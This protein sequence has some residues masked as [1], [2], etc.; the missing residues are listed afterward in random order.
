MTRRSL[1]ASPSAGHGRRNAALLAAAGAGAALAAFN[2]VRARRAER[3]HPPTGRLFAIGGVRVHVHMAGEGPPLVLLNGNGSMVHDWLVSG[4]FDRLRRS[5][6]VIAVDRPGYGYTERPRDRLWTPY[7]QAELVRRTLAHLGV[8]KPIVLGHSWGTIVA[9]ALAL[10]H[11]DAVRGL[12]LL[13]GYYFPTA[14]VDVWAFSPPAIPVFG[15]IM[16]YTVSP[17]LLRLLA[18]RIIRKLFEPMPVPPRFAMRFPLDLALRPSQLKASAEDSAL[19]VPA[20][21]GLQK[22]YGELRLPIEIL[23]GTE[24]RVVTP[25]RQ[26]GRLH[27]TIRGSELTRLPGLGHMV[28]YAA[29]DEIVRAVGAVATAADERSEAEALSRAVHPRAALEARPM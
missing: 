19:M 2:Y 11:P 10:E 18:P 6:R 28:H 1:P 12:V 9:L 27:E 23:T 17:F 13:S 16:R 3:R 15:D 5:Y 20:A 24:D 8:E 25:A 29:Q 22:R 14:R 21:A 26:S 4:L 7:A